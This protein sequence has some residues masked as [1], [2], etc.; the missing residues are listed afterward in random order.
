MAKPI[1]VAFLDPVPRGIPNYHTLIKK[2]MDFGTVLKRLATYPNVEKF[3]GDVEL[4]FSNCCL[5]NAAG[6][7]LASAAGVLR[8]EFHGA[9]EE[10]G[11]RSG[12][13]KRKSVEGGGESGEVVVTPPPRFKI[14][15]KL[16]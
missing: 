5:F 2:P 9:L 3:I 12:G 14:K 16:G 6:S 8:D 15:L 1:A 10:I 11:L 4:V 7:P 13:V